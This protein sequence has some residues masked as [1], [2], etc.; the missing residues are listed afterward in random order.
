[1]Q[2]CGVHYQIG[3]T[4]SSIGDCLRTYAPGL[5]IVEMPIPLGRFIEHEYADKVRTIGFFGYQRD[6]RGMPLVAPLAD[7]LIAL[8]YRVVIHDTLGQFSV[9]GYAGKLRLLKTF[10]GELEREMVQCDLVVCT[11]DRNRYLN[12][13]SGIVCNA[14]ACGVPLV[15]PAGTLSALRFFR[16]GSS[17]CY[18]EHTVEGIVD[19]VRR[20]DA[21]YPAYATAA[22]NAAL[23]WSKKNGVENYVNYLIGHFRLG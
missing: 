7:R 23:L 14:V 22:R 16:E 19:A 17:C 8:G 10:V 20:L 15:M 12:R 13:I 3:A 1:M 9:E 18:S 4:D 2:Q 21:N 11:A 5:P 6:E